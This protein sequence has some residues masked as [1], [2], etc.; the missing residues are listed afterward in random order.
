MKGP[1]QEVGDGVMTLNRSAARRIDGEANLLS[2]HRSVG[3]FEEVQEGG[4]ALLRGAD[5]PQLTGT[6]Q[7]AG[8]TDLAAHFGVAGGGVENDGGLVLQRHDFEDGG[9]GFERFVSEEGG[10]GL[11]LDL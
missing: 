5:A 1:V 6:G 9:L 8:V 2:G 10:G 11:G 7:L 3:A 4:A